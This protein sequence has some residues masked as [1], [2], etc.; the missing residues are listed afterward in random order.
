MTR[1][2]LRLCGSNILSVAE[3]GADEVMP[4]SS[5]P[6][7]TSSGRVAAAGVFGIDLDIVGDALHQRWLSRLFDRPFAPMA[8]YCAS[9][10]FFLAAAF[11]RRAASSRSVGAGVA[12]ED[13]VLAGL[14]QLR[15]DI[16]I[17]DHLGGPGMT[18]AHIHA[19]LDG[20]I[21]EQRNAMAARTGS[22]PRNENRQGSRR[23]RRYATWAGCGGS[24]ASPQ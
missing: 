9:V 4:A 22:L 11:S 8:R 19:G 24:R 1:A 20:W 2:T 21:Q 18:N 15:I 6:S 17:D 14:A 23:R 10:F 5:G 16:V 7:M 12:V 13:D 3:T